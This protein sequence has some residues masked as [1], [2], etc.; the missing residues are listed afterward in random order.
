MSS[1]DARRILLRSLSRSSIN[2]SNSVWAVSQAFRR[3]SKV[4]ILCSAR[5]SA[6]SDDACI[7]NHQSLSDR[8]VDHGN[9][10]PCYLPLGQRQ[11]KSGFGHCAASM[12]SDHS[13]CISG[14]INGD[15]KRTRSLVVSPSDSYCYRMYR[16][17][18]QKEEGK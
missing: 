15:N 14:W 16:R 17:S 3:S 18:L 4:S 6:G 8:C 9:R 13:V 11:D 12:L 2:W 1:G 7:Y 5:R 10:I